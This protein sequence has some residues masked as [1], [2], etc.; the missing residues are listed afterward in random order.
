MRL[1]VAAAIGAVVI[2][3]AAAATLGGVREDRPLVEVNDGLIRGITTNLYNITQLEFLGI[4]YA[5]PPLGSL[6]F[7]VIHTQKRINKYK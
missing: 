2:T 1:T 7:K 6:R 4:P 3:V 5:T